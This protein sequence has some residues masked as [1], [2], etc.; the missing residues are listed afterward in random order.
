M[1]TTDDKYIQSIQEQASGE[2]ELVNMLYDANYK[3]IKDQ[4]PAVNEDYAAQ[5]GSVASAFKIADRGTSE[6]LANIG[7]GSSGVSET[8]KL[9]NRIALENTLNSL[10]QQQRDA[11]RT[12]QSSIESL[13]LEKAKDLNTIQSDASDLI[14]QYA[15]EREQAQMQN[16]AALNAALRDGTA[17]A[18]TAQ[19]YLDSGAITPEYYEK[20]ITQVQT[21]NYSTYNEALTTAVASGDSAQV[22]TALGNADTLY[23]AG[24]LTAEQY[25]KM[26]SDFLTTQIAGIENAE[27]FETVAANLEGAKSKVGA[28]YDT[29][30][31]TLEEKQADYSVLSPEGAKVTYSGK[32]NAPMW[33]SNLKVEYE[34]KSYSV[35]RGAGVTIGKKLRKMGAQNGVVVYKGKLYYLDKGGASELAGKDYDALLDALT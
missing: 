23:K 1:A 20:Y 7:L 31:K 35:K 11:V 13:N 24:D 9:T 34:G 16:E 22:A 18:S 3:S 6:S 2:T 32:L 19:Y 5:R 30:Y 17:N 4:L 15:F 8:A 33:G 14:R 26:Y 25:N 28:N 29:L 27:E 10:T 21:K 12:I